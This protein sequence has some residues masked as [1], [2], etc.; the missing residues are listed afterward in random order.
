MSTTTHPFAPEEVMALIDG[1]LSADCEQ[2]LT[3]HLDQC[4]ECSVLA[5][6][7]RQA[8]LQMTSWKVGVVPERLGKQVAAAAIRS[9]TR[10]RPMQGSEMEQRR[11]PLLRFAF[12]IASGIGLLLLVAIS[13]PNLLRSRMAANEA[14]A[15]GSLRTLNTAAATYA[16]TYGHFPRSLEDFG[17]PS[18]GTPTE[19]AAGLID[20]VLAAG[21]KSGY[22]FVYHSVPDMGRSSK[23][24]YA[25]NADPIEP[26]ASGVR[27]FSTDETGAINADGV[28][29]SGTTLSAKSQEQDE[30]L[31]QGHD[32]AKQLSESGPMVARTAELKLVVVKVD[33]AREGMDRILKQHNGYVA[34]LSASTEG[35]SVPV[36]VASLRVPADQL[37]LCILELKKLGRVTQESQAGEEVTQQHSDLIARLK[38]SRNT[39]TR[40]GEVLQQRGGKIV[41]ILEV[42]K[43]SA[44]VRGEIEQMEAEQQ[45]LEHRVEFATIDL[46]LAEEYKAQLSSPAPSV[47]TQVRNAS[48]NGF[49]NAF[50][51]ALALVLF[52]AE[53]GPAALL[54]MVVLF[55]PVRMLW[56]RYRRGLALNSSLS[57]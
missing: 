42:E 33:E 25:I 48:V 24:G 14:S 39:E 28:Y 36:V 5:A 15:V 1:E 51:S 21:R 6:N 30:H 22:L 13:V 57:A 27:H 8:S 50:E 11:S 46:K 4:A 53:S 26:S 43:E 2:S 20:P 16:N 32:S 17:P 35:G 55:L 45:T 34:H 37:D 38:N 9:V 12:G 49:R 47:A 29:L 44:R 31:L 41:D 10:N 40:L 3:A 7:F 54:W 56:R 23:G 19:A 18:S 52:L